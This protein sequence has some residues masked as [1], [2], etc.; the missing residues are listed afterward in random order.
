MSAIDPKK[1]WTTHGLGEREMKARIKS[2]TAMR[3]K[4]RER[5]VTTWIDK[6]FSSPG[7]N[8]WFK[9]NPNSPWFDKGG[10]YEKYVDRIFSHAGS[11][12]NYNKRYDTVQGLKK[13]Q[14]LNKQIKLRNNLKK[15]TRGY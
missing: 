4:A 1:D 5:M 2:H 7:F 3:D 13:Q 10:G 8:M 11:R 6:D 12:R 15:I 14:A 9:N